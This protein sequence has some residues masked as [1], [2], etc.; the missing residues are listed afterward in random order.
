MFSKFFAN[1][2]K[3]RVTYQIKASRT[4][5]YYMDMKDVKRNIGFQKIFENLGARSWFSDFLQN[6]P[7]RPFLESNRKYFISVLNKNH[8]GVVTV[9]WGT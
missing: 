1:L 2:N 8:F 7:L 4:C 5:N 6:T 3:Y 9:S